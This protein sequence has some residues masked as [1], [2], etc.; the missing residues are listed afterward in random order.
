MTTEERLER[1]EREADA[2]RKRASQALRAD[3]VT[4]TLSLRIVE[5]NVDS[6]GWLVHAVDES[7]ATYFAALTDDFATVTVYAER[8]KLTLGH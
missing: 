5:D 6:P 1:L 4:G 8:A 2:A 7:G 3:G